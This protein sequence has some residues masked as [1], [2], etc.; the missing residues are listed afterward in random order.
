M[1]VSYY[2]CRPTGLFLTDSQYTVCVFLIVQ[3]SKVVYELIAYI[4]FIWTWM[5]SCIIGIHTTSPYLYSKSIVDK[6]ILTT[7]TTKCWFWTLCSWLPKW[8]KKTH[9]FHFRFLPTINGP[10][11]LHISVLLTVK[12]LFK[13]LWPNSYGQDCLLIYSGDIFLEKICFGGCFF[14]SWIAFKNVTSRGSC[15]SRRYLYF[16]CHKGKLFAKGTIWR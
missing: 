10:L 1:N 8:N 11:Y 12:N 4:H 5:D 6:H 14:L 15:S 13:R 16:P 3:G 7:T 9:K 2:L